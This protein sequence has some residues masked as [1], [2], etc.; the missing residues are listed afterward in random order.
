MKLR[1]VSDNPPRPGTGG[2]EDPALPG[3]MQPHPVALVD[4]H[5]HIH[6]GI[7]LVELLDAAAANFRAGARQVQLADGV[8][9]CL[10]L[11]ESAGVHRFAE[12]AGA[13]ESRIGRWWVHS[14]QEPTSLLCETEGEPVLA[15]VA[16]RQTVT[17]EQLEVLGWGVRTGVADGRPIEPTI[18]HIERLGGVPVL[19]WGLGKWIGRRGRVVR[20]LLDRYPPGRLYVSDN[21]GRLRGTLLPAPLRK[22][23]ARGRWNVPGSDPLPL[24]GQH[25][26]AGSYGLVLRERFEPVQPLASVVAGLGR[27][28][29]QPECYGRRSGPRQFLA[30][31]AKMQW[32]KRMGGSR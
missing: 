32:R 17:A 1:P 30:S 2:L 13:A 4:A 16:G 31:Q 8:P 20:D 10:M 5:V 26:R 27:T 14:T 15:V 22:A 25:R 3:V 18:E 21:G 24:P 12:L 6:P 28:S 19:P 23:V 11:A 7:R 29:G 9:G